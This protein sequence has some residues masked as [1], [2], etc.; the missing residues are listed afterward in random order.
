MSRTFT[1]LLTSTGGELSPQLIRLAQASTRH[2]I[3]V[4]ACEMRGDVLARHMA[5]A[6]ALVPAGIDPGYASAV[7]EIVRKEGVDLI[8]PGADEEALALSRAKELLAQ[9]G[10]QVAGSPYEYRSAATLR[11][12]SRTAP[13]FASFQAYHNRR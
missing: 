5:D 1:L 6:F 10:C 2:A 9:D 8:I 3:R 4:V 13:G 11:R 12:A 7:H